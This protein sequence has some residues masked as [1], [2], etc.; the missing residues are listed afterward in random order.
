MTADRPAKLL[1]ESGWY[2]PAERGGLVRVPD[3]EAER[4]QAEGGGWDLVK[5][6]IGADV[7]EEPLF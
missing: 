5:V 4:E 1:T 3:E 7:V 6:E 2:R